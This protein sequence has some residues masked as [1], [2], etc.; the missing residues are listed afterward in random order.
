MMFLIKDIS[1]DPCRHGSAGPSARPSVNCHR[2]A[3]FTLVAVGRQAPGCSGF[4]AGEF[5]N[6][7][8]SS[9]F[10]RTRDVVPATKSGKAPKAVNNSDS[11]YRPRRFDYRSRI[12][13]GSALQDPMPKASG[14]RITRAATHA[15]NTTRAAA[16]A[17]S[18]GSVSP[19]TR[20][21]A[22][23]SASAP[24]TTFTPVL[25]GYE[26]AVIGR[27]GSRGKEPH[28]EPCHGH[29]ACPRA[30]KARPADA[31]PPP[32]SSN[33]QRSNHPLERGDLC[34]RCRAGGFFL[35]HFG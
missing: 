27:S 32:H 21:A 15:M 8:N 28:I 13:S 19:I 24:P 30:A 29:G 10:S 2:T 6:K 34:R 1:L 20:E 14:Q 11:G 17:H 18:S 23:A 3:T 31:V 22:G 35:R 5:G 4:H 16:E 9:V 26:S 33:P 12:S 7:G 25:R